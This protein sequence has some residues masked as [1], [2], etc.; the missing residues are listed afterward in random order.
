MF[1]PNN[2]LPEIETGWPG[3]ALDLTLFLPTKALSFTSLPWVSTTLSPIRIFPYEF[4]IIGLCLLRAPSFALTT[5]L[6]RITCPS[7]ALV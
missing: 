5:A 1:L 4:Y 7:V 3:R 2:L 6:E